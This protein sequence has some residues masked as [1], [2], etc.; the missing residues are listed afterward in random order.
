MARNVGELC[1]RNVV[2]IRES[3]D[4]TAAARLMRE[5][6]AGVRRL[7]VLGRRGNL[8]PPLA[9]GKRARR[10]RATRGAARQAEVGRA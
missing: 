8:E 7:P 3:E 5:H 9:V 4:L 6:R 10:R 2:T 1:Q